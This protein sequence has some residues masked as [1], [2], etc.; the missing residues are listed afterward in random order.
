MEEPGGLQTMGWQRVGQDW[1]TSLSLSNNRE[2]TQPH[3]SIENWLK[4]LLS[5]APPIRTRPSFPL[6]QSLPSG[7][8]H[9]PFILISQR[10]DRMKTTITEMNQS[11]HMVTSQFSRSVMS[12]SLWP[13]ELQHTRP[14]CPSPT[15]GVHSNSRPSSR[16]YHPAISSSVVPFSSATIPSQYQSLFQWVNSS[17]E[18]AKVLEF[19]L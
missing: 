14:P 6:S 2:G 3:P 18:G 10:T 8:F 1:A 4:D 12:N 11:N 5:M 13:R 9:K 17:H 16:W 7:S 19:Q 15:S